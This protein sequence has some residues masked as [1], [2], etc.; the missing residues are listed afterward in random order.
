MSKTYQGDMDVKPIILVGSSYTLEGRGTFSLEYV[1]NAPGYN[2]EEADNY[3]TLRRDAATAF[4]TGGTMGLLGQAV[5]SQTANPGLRFLR[6]NYAMLQYNQTNIMNKI[7]LT[8]RWTQNLDDGSGQFL[9]LLS[10]SIGDHWE[11]FSSGVINAGPGNTE[12]GSTLSYQVMFGV[13]WVF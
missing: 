7:D 12:F 6:K 9:G 8:V 5:L 3:F 4:E 11:L 13:K 2:S 10:Y 1:Y